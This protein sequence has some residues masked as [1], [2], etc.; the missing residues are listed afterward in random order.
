[1]Y[2]FIVDVNS[3]IHLSSKKGT[4]IKIEFSTDT[5]ELIR[6][7]LSTIKS[8]TVSFKILA[9]KI[10]VQDDIDIRKS[11]GADPLNYCD[12]PLERLT[13]DIQD[14]IFPEFS[15]NNIIYYDDNN[16]YFS[17]DDAENTIFLSARPVLLEE[18]R[19]LGCQTVQAFYDGE[20]DSEAVEKAKQLIPKNP[21]FH[22]DIDE[23]I[24]FYVLTVCSNKTFLNDCAVEVIRQ[25]HELYEKAKL[26]PDFKY[27]TARHFDPVEND[28]KSPAS[29]AA[30]S[31]ALRKRINFF[32]RLTFYMESKSNILGNHPNRYQIFMDDSRTQIREITEVAKARGMSDKVV[33]VPVYKEGDL[34]QS[35]INAI[36]LFF[37]NSHPLPKSPSPTPRFPTPPFA[38]FRIDTPSDEEIENLDADRLYELME[39]LEFVPDSSSPALI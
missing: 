27:L 37:A 17:K 7:H 29:I 15:D 25:I 36:N 13:K 12:I 14:S 23:T 38:I 9:Y 35:A 4:D 6:E 30:V 24:L 26:K 20:V 3:L 2:T 18:M 39:Q 19:E 28:E 1:M 33:V 32:P 8:G 5:V 21:I 10:V 22:A 11:I 34:S 16:L 31:E